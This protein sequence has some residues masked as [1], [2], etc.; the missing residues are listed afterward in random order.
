MA[1]QVRIGVGQ[2]QCM[3]FVGIC[4]GQ[5]RHGQ[6]RD[7]VGICQVRAGYARDR[8]GIV[9]GQCEELN[10][11]I[12][13]NAIVFF[14][15]VFLVCRYEKNIFFELLK[16]YCFTTWEVDLFYVLVVCQPASWW[17]MCRLGIGKCNAWVGQGWDRIGYVY[18]RDD[19]WQGRVRVGIGQEHVR[20]RAG[21]M[22]DR[23]R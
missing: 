22:Y 14:L 15:M 13:Y 6:A 16:K 10:C 21:I 20:D 1:V 3:D 12:I 8:V 5:C 17:G 18:G 11:Y 7:R 4:Q 23:V 9:Q 19:V 2:G